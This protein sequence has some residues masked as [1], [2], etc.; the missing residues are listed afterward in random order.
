VRTSRAKRIAAS[1]PIP[2]TGGGRGARRDRGRQARRAA[3]RIRSALAQ[4]PQH[5][6][7]RAAMLR[8][9][10][11]AIADGAD[12]ETIVAPP[13]SD[14]ERAV[15]ARW[16]ARPT[17]RAASAARARAAARR[18]PAEPSARRRRGAA[19]RPGADRERRPALAQQA[20]ALAE[21]SLDDRPEPS[22]ILLRAEASAAAGD[23]SPRSRHS[24][25]LVE[26]L[27]PKVP[28]AIASCAERAIS[29]ARCPT[30]GAA[31]AA[32]GHAPA[33]WRGADAPDRGTARRRWRRR[34]R[35]RPGRA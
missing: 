15:A 8:L 26:Y 32:P 30:T 9:S 1:L 3:E 33:A 7:A 20:T 12:P 16:A 25:E 24:R 35:T 5:V 11:G 4:N 2:S 28:S 22:S 14:A 17:I 10:A 34:A 27:D 23:P 6:E 19:A 29:R 13:L 18:D 21:T 31:L